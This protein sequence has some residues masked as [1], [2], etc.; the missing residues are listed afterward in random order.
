MRSIYTR[1][2]MA[3]SA[4]I[5]IGLLLGGCGHKADTARPPATDAG[6][7]AINEPAEG[8]GEKTAPGETSEVV[9][10]LVIDDRTPTADLPGERARPGDEIETP[11]P[12]PYAPRASRTS[13]GET[14]AEPP[15]RAALETNAREAPVNVL[16]R[17]AAG[18]ERPLAMSSGSDLP[19][20][21]APA[22]PESSGPT[23]AVAPGE[24]M[25]YDMMTVFY[26]TD[27][28]P[29]DPSAA[30]AG[31]GTSWQPIAAAAAIACLLFVFGTLGI[32]RRWTW[33]LAA[34][35]L[36]ATVLLGGNWAYQQYKPAGGL[37]ELEL[38]YGNQRGELQLGTCDVSIPWTHTVGE[39]ERPSILRLEVR[40]DVRKHIVLQRIERKPDDAFFEQL[41]DR[42]QTA[43]RSE[44]FVFVHG[45][46]VT[47]EGAAQRTAQI[48]YD[49]NFAGAPIF[50]SWP[51]QG[52]LLKYTV[53][54]N[55]VEWAVPH[56][57]QFLLDIV[58]RSGAQSVNLIAHSMGNRA[59][60]AAL[61][62]LQLQ[63]R[64]ETELFNQIILAAPDVDA[65]IFRRDLAPA[66][67]RTA[68]H[69]TL[70]AS[71]NDQALAASK[72]V[73]GYARAGESGA[74]L[75][76]LPGIETVDVSALDTSLLGHSYYGSSNPILLDIGQLIDRALPAAERR[77]LL[78]RPYGNLT[79]WVFAKMSETAT[80]DMPR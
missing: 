11:Q 79:Y 74:D 20:T 24:E 40:E 29:V 50:F 36:T 43:D 38:R 46:N 70:Y 59:L 56:L 9:S 27:R 32:Q 49:V 44:V 66:L 78:P 47:F 18:D 58:Q 6:E 30:A 13:E 21:S 45:Y 48:A 41:R 65:E 35:A 77:W 60:T 75:V 37:A 10:P 63:L 23:D 17:E 62:E 39:I 5:L 57:R 67:V 14:A 7:T 26:A 16:R 54:E 42:V 64:N 31:L 4:W 28:Q 52:G 68:R 76:V 3:F 51:S 80:R 15:E 69:V 1:P 72:T 2:A 71:S 25:P 34:V 55:N 73:H 61:R 33:G 19:E 22:A 53:D 12:R 8:G